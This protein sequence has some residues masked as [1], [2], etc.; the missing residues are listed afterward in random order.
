VGLIIVEASNV[1]WDHRVLDIN[2]GIYDDH[3]IPGLTQLAKC[4]KAHG[5]RAFIQLIHAGNMSQVARRVGPSPIKV[6]DGPLPEELTGEEIE[7]VKE[8]FVE[9]ARRAQAAGFDGVELHGAHLWLL[10]AFL[11]PYTN[12]RTDKHGGPLSNRARLIMDIIA[13]IRKEVGSFPLSC[14]FDAYE[15]IVRGIE[16]EEG[17]EIA[18]MLE[19][20]GVDVLHVSG[21]AIPPYK[22][23]E[24]AKFTFES[25]PAFLKGYPD[26]CHIPCAAIIKEV[27]DVPVIGVGM[28]RSAGFAEQVMQN[29]MCDLLAMGRGLMA[30][31]LFVEKTL[32]GRGETIIQCE[33]C[34]LCHQRFFALQPIECQVNPDL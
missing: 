13:G 16:I 34:G 25:K 33:D 29:G 11:S 4:I 32:S 6:W 1:L 24:L 26:R 9:A 17:K 12:R 20:A 21:V 14:R 3:C 28:V 30:D 31:P 19:Q 15:N 22:P 5:A 10:S 18:R 27:V 8:W 2:I 7:M 23:D